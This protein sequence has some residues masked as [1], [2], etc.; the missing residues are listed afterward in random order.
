MA[1]VNVEDILKQLNAMAQTVAELQTV[2]E[3]PITMEFGQIPDDAFLVKEGDS[4]G[5]SIADLVIKTA[6]AYAANGYIK[7][8]KVAY[9][10]R[11]SKVYVKASPNRQNASHNPLGSGVSGYAVDFTTLNTETMTFDAIP[12]LGMEYD[13]QG[14]YCKL[15]L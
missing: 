9:S 2:E 12:C 7:N 1:K 13:K 14:F 8:V 10:P 4:T 5:N 3:T 6:F 15:C 11:A